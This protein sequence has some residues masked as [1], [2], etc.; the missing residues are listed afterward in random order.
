M[1]IFV[2]IRFYKKIIRMKHKFLLLVIFLYISSDVFVQNLSPKLSRNTLPNFG[3]VE[4]DIKRPWRVAAEVGDFNIFVNR[5]DAWRKNQYDISKDVSVQIQSTEFYN[6]TLPNFGY[7]EQGIKRPWRV[8]AEVIGINVVVNR[9]GD[10]IM[11]EP[12]AHVTPKSWKANLEHGFVWDWNSFGTN[13]FAHPYHGALYHTTARANGLNFWESVPFVFMGSFI[14]E[15]FGE[16]HPPSGNDYII[17]TLGG[18]QLGEMLFRMSELVLDDRKR[19]RKRTTSEIAATLITPM[20]GLNRLIDGKFS[21][22]EKHIN[23]LRQPYQAYL[24]L[25]SNAFVTKLNQLKENV[26][27]VLEFGIEYGDPFGNKNSYKPYEYFKLM[28]WARWIR[29]EDF[30]KVYLSMLSTGLIWGKNFN[31][32]EKRSDLFGIFQHYDYVINPIIEIGGVSI[33]AGWLREIRPSDMWEIQLELHLGMIVLGGS[34]SEIADLGF[35]DDLGYDLNR[36]YVLGP[37]IMSKSNFTIKHKKYGALSLDYNR[38]VIYVTSGPAGEENLRYLHI[39]Y[40]IP[41]WGKFNAGIEYF[42]Y[43]RRAEYDDVPGYE[44]V[45]KTYYEFKTLLAYYF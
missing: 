1:Y 32:K 13:F 36:T 21:T 26:G 15:Y 2:V 29:V 7:V 39:R 38:R 34:N 30:S 23:H 17:T 33:A 22:H 19:G 14:W 41:I 5:K 9:F 44:N 43:N 45:K 18:I 4:Q 6:D 27:P 37:G 28:T 25:G 3:Q 10:W 16:N 11:H 12:G 24:S 31:I 20:Y 8:A 35:S 40:F 42:Q